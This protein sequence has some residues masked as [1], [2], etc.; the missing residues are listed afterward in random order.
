MGLLAGIKRGVVAAE[1]RRLLKAYA[2][3]LAQW[4][5]SVNEE[6]FVLMSVKAFEAKEGKD[7]PRATTHRPGAGQT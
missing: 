6:T 5:V 1:V 2:P 3:L 4:G 7:A